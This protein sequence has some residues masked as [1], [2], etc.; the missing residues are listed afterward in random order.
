VTAQWFIAQLTG[1][2]IKDTQAGGNCFQGL[3]QPSLALQ[4]IGISPDDFLDQIL[5]LRVLN[6]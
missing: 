3:G 4:L 1:A 5:H 2:C 6:A